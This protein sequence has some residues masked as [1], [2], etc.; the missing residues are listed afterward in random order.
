L[1]RAFSKLINERLGS[2]YGW[3]NKWFSFEMTAPLFLAT[4]RFDPSNGEKWRAYCEWAK[5]PG[6]AEVV[7][8][9]SLLCR[10]LIEEFI[11]E[12]WEHNVH[13]DF[14]LDYF[15]HLGYL[16]LRINNISRRN[17]LGLYRNPEVHITDAPAAGDFRFV[18]YD[19]IEEQTQISA[20]TNCGG[21][22]DVFSNEELNRFGLID[23]FD[24]A[25]SVRRLLAELHPE[26]HHA[27]CQMYAI[28]RLNERNLDQARAL[29]RQESGLDAVYTPLSGAVTSSYRKRWSYLTRAAD[30]NSGSSCSLWLFPLCS[31]SSISGAPRYGSAPWGGQMQ[32]RIGEGSGK[33]EA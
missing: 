13:E 26:E 30:F 27:Q 12:D 16:K 25:F 14:R 23:S 7:S 6:L 19:L 21:F 31:K 3:L 20:L 28:W 10:R 2:W 1:E 33:F 8:L 4:E 11:D 5:I 24:R 15:Y 32:L 9:D 17:V 29:N 22:P 18:G